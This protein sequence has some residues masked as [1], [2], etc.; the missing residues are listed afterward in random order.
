METNYKDIYKRVIFIGDIIQQQ[1]FNGQE[2]TATYKVVIDKSDNKPSLIMLRG[3]EQAMKIKGLRAFGSNIKG[4]LK[5]GL[6]I[7]R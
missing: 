6:I 7:N 2:Y 1:N 5:K 3:N 4:Q